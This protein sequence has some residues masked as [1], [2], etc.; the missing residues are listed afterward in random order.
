VDLGV[1]RRLGGAGQRPDEEP[2]RDRRWRRQRLKPA[3]EVDVGRGAA[4]N[5]AVRGGKRLPALV[6]VAELHRVR[7]RV[8]ALR[9]ALAEAPAVSLMRA[10][11][12][13]LA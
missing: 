10:S 11:L 8:P 7:Q 5:E 1:G 9:V 4:V 12:P 2:G 6:V 13:L 3:L